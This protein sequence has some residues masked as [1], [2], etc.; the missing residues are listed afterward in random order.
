MRVGD[1]LGSG[2]ISGPEPDSLGCLLEITWRGT[3]PLELPN[4]EQRKYISDNDTVIMTGWAQG[5]GYRIGF[6]ECVGKVLPAPA[7]ADV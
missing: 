7:L 5:Q 6:G 3:K 4:G 2:T 1:V